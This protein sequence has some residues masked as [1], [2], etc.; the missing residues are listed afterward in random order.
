MYEPFPGIAGRGHLARDRHTQ[1]GIA[2]VL[3][4]HG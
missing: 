2:L 4:L 1:V 3:V